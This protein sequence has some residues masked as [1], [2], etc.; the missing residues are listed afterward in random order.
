[1]EIFIR[2]L[3]YNRFC[4]GVPL[5]T[6]MCLQ[7]MSFDENAQSVQS[8]R[9]TAHDKYLNGQFL[10]NQEGVLVLKNGKICY[11]FKLTNQIIIL[12]R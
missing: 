10:C 11:M 1:M 6:C 12:L 9:F 7:Y 8:D 2:T 5:L 3:I 4:T